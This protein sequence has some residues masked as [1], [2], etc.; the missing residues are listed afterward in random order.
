MIKYCSCC[1]LPNW[2]LSV[3]FI[4]CAQ[5]V[6]SIIFCLKAPNF[7]PFKLSDVLRCQHSIW[8]TSFHLS[9]CWTS[10][11]FILLRFHVI[12]VILSL[13][14]QIFFSCMEIGIYI[15]CP[16]SFKLAMP[17][18]PLIIQKILSTSQS[19]VEE[20]PTWGGPQPELYC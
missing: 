5:I 8:S 13:Q 1:I 12:T 4:F 6:N 7:S 9:V 19:N 15:R 17:W 18:T 11:R 2:K 3:F 10:T 14:L 20:H 16:E